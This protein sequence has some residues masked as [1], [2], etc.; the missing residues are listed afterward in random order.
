[1]RL[2]FPSFSEEPPECLPEPGRGLG[3]WKADFVALFQKNP[4]KRWGGP[5]LRIASD[6]ILVCDESLEIVH[7][8]RA[9]LKAIG[10]TSGSY[11]GTGLDA[12]FPEKERESFLAIFQEWR[13]G[14]AAGMRLHAP[15]LTTRGARPY[16]FRVVRCRDR[17]GKYYYYLIGR[18]VLEARRNNR[19]EDGEG[20]D[21][22][23]QGL[24]V[25]AWR[26]D[27]EL[28]IT[29]VYG[30]LWP[31]L[32]AASED[33]VG[34]VFGR[35]HDTLLPEV[36][37]GIDCSDTLAGMSLQTELVNGTECF[38]VTVE[39]FLDSSGRVVGTVGLLRRAIPG[40]PAPSIDF[41]VTS[42]APTGQRPRHHQ[43]PSVSGGISIVTG[44]VPRFFETE[45]TGTET[46]P[47]DPLMITRRLQPG[48]V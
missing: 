33:L 41:R 17:K 43:P 1:M 11:R 19:S 6:M 9:F 44:L 18:E 31:E 10:H 47:I 23:F 22:F 46:R 26:T 4:E 39:P 45:E 15:L 2:D 12:F 5:L 3:R 37:R 27:P 7:H 48:S 34:E 35:R 30:S 16:D 20:G 13:R 25:A 8:N 40:T 36:L 14:H 28:R 21:P 24:P 42:S 32:G 29:K 38:N